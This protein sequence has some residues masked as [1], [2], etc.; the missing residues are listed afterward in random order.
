[1]VR[2]LLGALLALSPAPAAAADWWYLS[3][4]GAPADQAAFYADRESRARSADRV[5]IREAS[6]YERA[7]EGSV[8]GRLDVVYDCRQRTARIV[9]ALFYGPDGRERETSAG[10][11]AAHGVEPGSVYEATMRFA[12]G[13][14][15]GLEQL[16][17][18][19]VREHAL[20]LFR[21]RADH[22]AAHPEEARQDS[23]LEWGQSPRSAGR[24][25][26]S[27]RR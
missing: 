23:E 25:R 15:E 17:A 2:I 4:A 16:G 9:H 18:L 13:E 10:D 8:S 26:R 12:C 11:P 6:E 5:T 3:V 22:L 7:A 20:L 24:A 21:E 14:E 27:R 19:G 1:M